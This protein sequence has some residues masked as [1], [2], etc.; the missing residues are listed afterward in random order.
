ML[1]TS[2]STRVI[3]GE[4]A[5]H[6]SYSSRYPLF[7]DSVSEIFASATLTNIRMPV[8]IYPDKVHNEARAGRYHFQPLREETL[9]RL[10]GPTFSPEWHVSQ[11][12]A[13]PLVRELS[14]WDYRKWEH[15]IAPFALHQEC[16]S[17]HGIITMPILMGEAQFLI[18]IH[19][20]SHFIPNV[21]VGIQDPPK[22][23][24]ALKLHILIYIIL[25][26]IFRWARSKF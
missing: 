20:Y 4:N 8:D 9:S 21:H 14:L 22:L 25:S 26:F 19:E 6:G 17:E 11:Y 3:I 10:L 13:T 5:K 16:M 1:L 7:S 2:L 18:G 24:V 15:T 23:H 12:T